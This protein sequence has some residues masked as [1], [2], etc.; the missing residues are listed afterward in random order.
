MR[1]QAERVKS[2]RLINGYR[3]KSGL[4]NTNFSRLFLRMHIA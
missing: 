3:E 1:P 4:S 2:A